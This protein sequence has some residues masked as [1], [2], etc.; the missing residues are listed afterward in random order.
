RFVATFE[1]NAHPLYVDALLQAS[2]GDTVLT[3]A[4][5]GM[6]PDAPHRVLRSCVAAAQDVTDEIVA[7]CRWAPRGFRCPGSRCPHRHGMRQAPLRPWRFMPDSP[8]AR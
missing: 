1:A 2:A 8:W 6:W 5:S 3:T 4:F 7:E